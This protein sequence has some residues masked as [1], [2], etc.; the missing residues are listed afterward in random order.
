MKKIMATI[1]DGGREYTFE[2]E[3]D[4]ELSVGDRVRVMTSRGETTA[5]VTALESSYS[6]WCQPVLYVTA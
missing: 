4:L 1:G 3:D 5:T 6:G 2:A